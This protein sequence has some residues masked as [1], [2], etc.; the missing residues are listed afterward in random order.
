MI[1][2]CIFSLAIAL[3]SV[4]PAVFAQNTG[5]IAGTVKEDGTSEPLTGAAVTILGTTLG[6]NT[7]LDGRFVLVNVPIGEYTVEARVAGYQ[8]NKIHHVRV[9]PSQTSYIMFKLSSV[10]AQVQ[11]DIKPL[12]VRSDSL[13]QTVIT[14]YL[15]APIEP[16]S[17]LI[18]CATFQLAWNELKDSIIRQNI[19]LEGDPIEARLLNKQLFDKKY[20]DRNCYVARS[21]KLSRSVLEDIN[22]EL[23]D[24]FGQFA[25][26]SLKIPVNPNNT[27]FLSYAFLYKNLRFPHRFNSIDGTIRFVLPDS[28]IDI[29]SFGIS[30]TNESIAKQLRKQVSVLYYNSNDDFAVRLQTTSN[31]DELIL[32]KTE[33]ASTLSTTIEKLEQNIRTHRT[34]SLNE[35]DGLAIPY[36]DF[37]IDHSYEQLSKRYL[38]NPGWR[39]YYIERALQ[40]IKFQLDEGGATLVST[41]TVTIIKGI[42]PRQFI[43]NKP[44]LVVLKQKGCAHPFFAMWVANPELLVLDK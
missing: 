15:E 3:L 21:G 2:R 4:V 24:K 5:K 38:L 37:D 28:F 22:G 36:I 6:V 19:E 27:S 14:P 26:D 8:D 35:D 23:H 31:K 30:A 20:L 29:K 25:P 39:R 11:L 42:P 44:F 10:P 1:R 12:R 40:R 9:L 32:A 33:H 34:S 7:D 13:E 43:F 17:N 18:Y 16:N 41:A